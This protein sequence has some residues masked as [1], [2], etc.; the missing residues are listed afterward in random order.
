MPTQA[1]VDHYK[2]LMETGICS[3]GEHI[4]R[5]VNTLDELKEA[6]SIRC[7]LLR[8]EVV[9]WHQIQRG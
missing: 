4:D 1:D 8:G 2:K 3:C 9:A 6:G 7:K 5:H